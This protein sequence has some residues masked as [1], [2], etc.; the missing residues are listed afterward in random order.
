MDGKLFRKKEKITDKKEDTGYICMY[1]GNE[2]YKNPSDHGLHFSH[3]DVYGKKFVCDECDQLI[4]KTNVMLKN[5][6]DNMMAGE[7]RNAKRSIRDAVLHLS[8]Y[9]SGIKQERET[10]RF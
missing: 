9:E 1:C 6:I 4:T 2:G 3:D 5:A 10:R 7:I 8:R